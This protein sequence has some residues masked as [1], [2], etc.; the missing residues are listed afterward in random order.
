MKKTCIT[1]KGGKTCLLDASPSIAR[2]N[3]KE[4]KIELKN[5]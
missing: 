4:P 5:Q 1:A 2:E 3:K